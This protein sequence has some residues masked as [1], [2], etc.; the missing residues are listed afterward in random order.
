MN[1]GK[2]ECLWK[3]LFK[4]KRSLVVYAIIIVLSLVLSFIFIKTGD[5]A[6]AEKIK[7]FVS[8]AVGISGT[9]ASLYSI[10]VSAKSDLE[11]NDEKK[12]RED[13]FKK[14]DERLGHISDNTDYIK[15]NV[16]S[17]LN[18]NAIKD[19]AVCYN[20]QPTDESSNPDG[21]PDTSDT[22]VTSSNTWNSKDKSKETDVR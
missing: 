19:V 15:N 10:F 4:Y 21:T 13:F 6:V 16:E 7:A 9:M 2:K 5:S 1:N 12:A 11:L 3:R 18:N 20:M 17:V 8:F 22:N 14:L